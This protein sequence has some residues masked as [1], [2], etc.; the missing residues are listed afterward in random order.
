M[1][2]PMV[3]L[4]DDELEVC[5]IAFL[6]VDAVL[7]LLVDEVL[8]VVVQQEGG[9]ASP[10]GALAGGCLYWMPVSDV[11]VVLKKETAKPGGVDFKGCDTA[12]EGCFEVGGM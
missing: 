11:E 2:L 12:G 4:Q 6:Q 1:M 5:C 10:G 3:V 7:K 9:G 8:Q